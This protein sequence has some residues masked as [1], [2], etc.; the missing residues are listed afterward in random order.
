M[1]CSDTTLSLGVYLLGALDPAERAQVEG[2]LTTCARCRAELEELAQLPAMLE[3]VS[4]DDLTA[5][6]F[7]PSDDLFERVAAR[8]RAEQ[9]ATPGTPRV[10]RYRRLVA[11]A[12][13]LVLV[14][15]VGFGSWA[16]LRPHDE[17]YVSKGPIQMSVT[18][19]SQATG[20][21]LAVSVSGLPTDEH[22]RLIAIAKDGTRD[23][24]GSWDAT[25][26][27]QANVTGSTSI[28]RSELAQLVLFGTNGEH[29]ATVSV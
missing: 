19:A 26:Q 2:H 23:V 21:R 7:P 9:R 3:Q 5:D 13:A 22:C 14:L 27:G 24:A 12:A 6:P 25:Y 11:V 16:A 20:T 28:P 10:A 15:G 1:T 17:K 29:L 8:A 4:L 18:L